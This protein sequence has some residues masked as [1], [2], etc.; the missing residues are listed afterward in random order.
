MTVNHLISFDKAEELG[1]MSKE[2]R[3]GFN[4]EIKKQAAYFMLSVSR[5]VESKDYRTAKS[6][7]IYI[8]DSCS[9]IEDPDTEVRY[10]IEVCCQHLAFIREMEGAGREKRAVETPSA[11]SRSVG[12]KK[13][14][15]VFRYNK[16]SGEFE[17]DE[18]NRDSLK[19]SVL[20]YMSKLNSILFNYQNTENH[21]SILAMLKTYLPYFLIVLVLTALLFIVVF[22]GLLDSLNLGSGTVESQLPIVACCLLFVFPIVKI[23]SKEPVKKDSI[24]FEKRLG[25]EILRINQM[26]A[27]NGEKIKFFMPE[28]IE[29]NVQVDEQD[30]L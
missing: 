19:Q 23:Y 18:E 28:G 17:C 30:E 8:A 24:F 1:K 20:F 12:E 14:I 11:E 13:P 22:S 27:A 6:I 10:L 2:E 9:C 21:H 29:I 26:C 16:F 3:V 4:N 5:A 15:Y 25:E 7:L